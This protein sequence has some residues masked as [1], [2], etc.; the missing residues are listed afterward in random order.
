L[1]HPNIYPR[2]FSCRSQDASSL[3][4]HSLVRECRFNRRCPSELL[5]E[6]ILVKKG[7]ART[8]GNFVARQHNGVIKM[9]NTES[10]FAQ[11]TLDT[12]SLLMVSIFQKAYPLSPK[13]RAEIFLQH[14]ASEID[15]TCGVLK[16]LGLVEEASSN[17]GFKPTHRLIEII[18]DR[19]VQPTVESKN[20]A[21]KVN[22]NFIA[23]SLQELGAGDDYE[24]DSDSIGDEQKHVDGIEDT[25]GGKGGQPFCLQVLV[26]LGLLREKADRYMPTRL[27]HKLLKNAYVPAHFLRKRMLDYWLQQL[28]KT[29]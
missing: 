10:N 15:Q 5:A 4:A 13:P 23:D 11:A 17:L 6:T 18:T 1:R 14:F 2:F 3:Y 26:F 8:V 12:D 22:R 19:M 29:A 9:L 16:L 20:A 7:C 24:D 21:A 27:M 25:E 28:S